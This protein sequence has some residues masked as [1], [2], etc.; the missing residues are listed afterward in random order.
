M[1]EA[2]GPTIK[3]GVDDDEDNHQHEHMHTHILHKI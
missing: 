3:G 2:E 1:N